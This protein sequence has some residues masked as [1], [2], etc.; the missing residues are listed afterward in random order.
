MVGGAVM[1]EEM[2]KITVFDL[3]ADDCPRCGKVT[4]HHDVSRAGIVRCTECGL[5]RRKTE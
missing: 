5:R 4:I 2:G 1:S 3:S